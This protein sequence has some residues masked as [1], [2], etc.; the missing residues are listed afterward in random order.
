[1]PRKVYNM[2]LQT[3]VLLCLE[4]FN[5]SVQVINWRVEQLQDNEQ[6]K[7]KYKDFLGW[8]FFPFTIRHGNINDTLKI[9]KGGFNL[10][11]H[12][13]NKPFSCTWMMSNFLPEVKTNWK[14]K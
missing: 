2:T 13:K 6:E 1:M 9:V 3:Y 7:K 11:E 4:I 10:L 8:I 5:F 14:H 12:R